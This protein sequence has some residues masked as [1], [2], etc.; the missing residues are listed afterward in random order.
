MI[1]VWALERRIYQVSKE[2][3]YVQGVCFMLIPIGL[4][5]GGLWGLK[6]GWSRNLGP[7]ASSK[8]RLNSILN[9]CTRR[10]TLLGNSLGVLGESPSSSTVETTA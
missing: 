2:L 10:G 1:C 5:V 8:L 4:A 6:E 7:T 9:A 3:Q